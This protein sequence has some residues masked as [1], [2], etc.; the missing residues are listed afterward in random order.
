MGA[1]H[2]AFFLATKT[3]C[4]SLCRAKVHDEGL[5]QS[6]VSRF[7]ILDLPSH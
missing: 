2:H 3:G 1:V 6:T 4:L 7:A 5:A